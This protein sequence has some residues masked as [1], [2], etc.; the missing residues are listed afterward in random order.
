ML[1]AAVIATQLEHL[2]GV[3]FNLAAIAPPALPLC[4]S[5]ERRGAFSRRRQN[6]LLA[7]VGS[8]LA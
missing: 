4:V 1:D 7:K 3:S 5:F 2:D 6:R 8:K